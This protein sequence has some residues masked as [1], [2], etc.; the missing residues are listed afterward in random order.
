MSLHLNNCKQEE[1][2]YII[3]KKGMLL[4]YIRDDLKTKELCEAAVKQ[5]GLAIKYVLY[6]LRTYELCTMAKVNYY[7]LAHFNIVHFIK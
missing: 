2:M 7:Y 1:I 5:K 3:S 4:R 6:Q